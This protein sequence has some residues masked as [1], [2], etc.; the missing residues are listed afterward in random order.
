MQ[1]LKTAIEDTGI[2]SPARALRIARTEVG[3]AS[4][5]GQLAAGAAAGAQYK[6]WH[7]SGF[8]VRD[9]HQQRNLEVVKLD[10]KFMTIDGSSP[11]FPA[12]Y[13]ASA[14]DRINCRC[15]MTF[16]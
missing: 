5:I 4:S 14:K 15:S 12:D 13:L 11:R 1:E 9:D 6:K 7:D 2:F 16:E 10:D 8:E 3:T